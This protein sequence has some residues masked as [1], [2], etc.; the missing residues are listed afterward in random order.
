MLGG[1]QRL[2][3]EIA[4][5]GHRS[6]V[7][8][9]SSRRCLRVKSAGKS[10]D[11]AGGSHTYSRS[12]LETTSVARS[13]QDPHQMLDVVHLDVEMEGVE[14]SR[15]ARSGPC[16][17]C[18]RRGCRGCRR[19]TA[20][21]PGSFLMTTH[22]RAAPP[23]DSSPQARS[24]QSASTPSARLSQPIMWTSIP[25]ALAPQADDPVARDR[26]A[27]FGELEGDARGQA[28]DR[29]GGA[30]RR[31]LDAVLDRRARHQRLHHRD[32][33]DP[34]QRDRLHQRLV[35]GQMQAPQRLGDR[36]PAERRRQ[37]LDDLVE[38]LAARARPSPRAPSI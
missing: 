17:R 18:W 38:D 23:S 13:R 19:S 35:I 11:V 37:P 22:S 7:G 27:A 33:V 25:V 3:V 15:R 16:R 2:E 4:A 20:S 24:T 9:R 36:F 29:D 14:A 31:R 34:L 10:A 8:F 28:L 5:I 21:E 26:V 1:E 32:V 30:L 12:A 6:R